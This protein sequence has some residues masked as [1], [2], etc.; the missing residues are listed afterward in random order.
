[1]NRREFLKTSAMAGSALAAA[2]LPEPFLKS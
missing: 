1:M 2:A